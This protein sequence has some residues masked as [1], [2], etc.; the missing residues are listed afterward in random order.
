[1]PPTLSPSHKDSN[2]RLAP[3]LVFCS[4]AML[5]AA[6]TFGS[7]PPAAPDEWHHYM[8]AVSIGHGQLVGK[9]GGREGAKALV[10][11]R[12]ANQS[13]QSY[14]D[15]LTTI[16]QTNRWVQIPPG[17]SPGWSRCQQVDP[18]VSARCLTDA[19]PFAEAHDWF[20]SAATYQPLPYLVPAALSLIRVHPD[21]LERLMRAGKALISLL[22]LGAGIFLLWNPRSQLV[23][24]VG[25]VVATTPMAVFLSAS[26][27]PS[28]LEIISALAFIS[29]LLRLT[30]QDTD[31]QLARWAWVTVGVS[32]FV[33]A[34]S[35]TT[36]PVWIVLSL[37]VTVLAGARAFLNM[38]VQWKRWSGPALFAVFLAILLN[39]WWEYVY[40]L[41]LPIDLTP[42]R[43]SLME[44][45]AQ[46]PRLLMEQVGVFNYLEFAMPWWAYELWQALAVALVATAL[47][48]ATRPQRLLLL[49]SVAAVIAVPV[50][51]VAATMRHTGFGA[52][53]RYFLAFSM[54]VPLLAGEILVRGYERLRALDAHR[55]FLPF[56]ATAA[57]VQMIAWWINARRFA[58]GVGGR[59]WFLSSAEW[60]P[61]WG[62]AVWM[63]LAAG[64]GC[65]LVAAAVM[66]ILSGRENDATQ[67]DPVQIDVASGL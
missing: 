50:V 57:F 19:P 25:L 13:E 16:A 61:P 5:F 66:E 59:E 42:L 9:P 34:L 18:N 53:G 22:L 52:Q 6:W 8:R 49:A 23:S 15:M 40:G 20:I 63:V 4:Y 32:G 60:S 56:A 24:L 33:L 35:R 36:G 10:G 44:G 62:W 37:A 11:E 43:A 67:G 46:L 7:P 64:G 55:L 3:F 27:N 54:V 2:R 1:M 31:H 48:V 21:N 58:V 65:L 30:R 47:L 41:R 14:E 12:P 26:L 51:L 39:R 28:G 17:L 38:M 45:L 29:A